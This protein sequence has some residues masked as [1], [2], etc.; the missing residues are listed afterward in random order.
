MSGSWR[1]TRELIG[2]GAAMSL[3]LA[4]CGDRSSGVTDSGTTGGTTTGGETGG[5]TTGGETGGETTG[6]ETTGGETTGGETTGGETTGGETT[7]GETTGQ[8]DTEKITDCGSTI[9]GPDAGT[10]RVTPGGATVLLRGDVMTP[11]GR[12]LGGEVLVDGDTILCVSCDCSASSAGATVLDCPEALITPGLV[13]PHDHIGW[14]QHPPVDHGDE[15]YDHRH[16]WRKGQ[17]GKTKISAGMNFSGDGEIWGEMRMVL[18]GATSMMGSGGAGGFV[19]NLDRSNLLE[20]LSH[21][22]PDAPTFP[23]GDTSGKRLTSGCDYP[24]A[25][26]ADQLASEVAYVPHVAEGVNDAAR[27]EFLCMSG[28]VPGSEDLVME[29]SAFI[30]GIGVTSGDI[31]LMAADSTGLI[32]SPRSNIS[33]YGFTAEVGVYDRQGVLIALGSDWAPS[34]SIN[35]L[36]ELRC[37]GYLNDMHYGGYFTDRALVDMVTQN[38]AELAG[39]ADRLGALQ[40][41]KL[42][43][44]TIWDASTNSDYRAVLDAEPADVALVLRGGEVLYGDDTLVG[45]LNS[46]TACDAIDI[47]GVSKQLCV[48]RETG[49]TFDQVETSVTGTGT[50]VYDNYPL[51]FCGVPEGEPTC[52]PSRPGEFTGELTANDADGDG[53]ADGSDNCPTW[54]NPPR[55]M[56]GGAQPNADGDALGDACDPCPFDMDT[57]ACTSVDPTD[58]DGDGIPN[59]SDNCPSLNNPDQANADDDLRGD[60]CDSCPDYPDPCLSSVYAIKKGEVTDGTAVSLPPMVVTAVGANGYWIQHPAG[61]AGYDGPEWSGIFVFDPDGAATVQRGDAL[62]GFSGSVTTYFGQKELESPGFTIGETPFGEPE[63]VLVADPSELATGGAKADAFEGVLVRVEDVEVLELEPQTPQTPP[64]GEFMVTGGLIVNDTIFIFLPDVGDVLTS[65]SGVMAWNWENNKLH[66]RDA[67][68]IVSGPPK[69]KSFGPEEVFI[70]SGVSGS[71]MPPLIAALSGP[72]QGVVEVTVVSDAPGVVAPQQMIWT[73]QPGEQEVEIMLSPGSGSGTATLTAS[74]PDATLTAMVIVIGPDDAPEVAGLDPADQ[75]AAWGKTLEY[76]VSLD[77]PAGPGG[78]EVQLSYDPAGLVS[79]PASVVVPEGMLSTTF[80]VTTLDTAGSVF[81]SAAAGIGEPHT[82][83]LEIVEPS[84]V[85]LILMEVLYDPPADDD[86]LEWIKLYNGTNGTIDLSGYSVGWGGTDYTYGNVAL[87][88]TV[89]PGDC[90]L[91]GGP[92]SDATNGSPVYDQEANVEPDI[93]NSGSKADG[94]ALFD[95]PAAAITAS[96]VPIDAVI[97]GGSN[98]SN[99]LDESGAP[100]NVDIGDA[101]KGH[102]IVRVSPTEWDINATPNAVLCPE[103]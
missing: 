65:V 15:R 18:G 17:N 43:D 93:Q 54:F 38:G 10:C 74:T 60:A 71:A 16:E 86:G 77:L 79:A 72:A 70:Y 90:F 22:V 53:I 97:Y 5:D 11:E 48:K 46:G 56:D 23:L 13:N 2:L 62:E 27:N 95:V 47:C 100:G 84:L 4:G 21:G 58:L 83:T 89:E 30:H 37:A 61:T 25:P 35:L 91:I 92:T 36:R 67:A 101:P 3:V 52:V 96:T 59:V 42:A 7:G 75:T 66:P 45:A 20:G 94:V 12:L 76:T 85:G 41:G 102:S 64:T 69:L 28:Q 8:T 49:M 87:A 26:N 103:L 51:H 29:N 98:D 39:F 55:V 31:A 1:M 80:E 81:I 44:I 88:G 63:A 24:K 50:E 40:Q 32:W 73:L 14:A 9:E 99:L 6:G 34:G 33:L 82:A 78:M 68:D 19:R 57:E